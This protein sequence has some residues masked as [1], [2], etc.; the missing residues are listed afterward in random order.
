MVLITLLAAALTFTI[1]AI[2]AEVG[3]TIVQPAYA[4]APQPCINC[5]ASELAP[6][7]EGTKFPGDAQ[8]FAPGQE[9]E[10]GVTCQECAVEFTP[11]DEG[12]EAGIIGPELKK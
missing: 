11:G 7:E 5:G 2:V 6:G 12:L 9:A 3:F 8:N 1:V 4:I 10:I